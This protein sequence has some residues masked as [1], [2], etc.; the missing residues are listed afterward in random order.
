[1]WKELKIPAVYTME[2]SFC[3]PDIGPNSG[4]HYTTE[5]LMEI[6]RKLCLSLLIYCDIDVPK[7]ITDLKK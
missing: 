2:A 3:G 7:A 5:H 4:F 6:G 1:M